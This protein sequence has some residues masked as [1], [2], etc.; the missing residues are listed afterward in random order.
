MQITEAEIKTVKIHSTK[1]NSLKTFL[2]KLS[3]NKDI[4]TSFIYSYTFQDLTCFNQVEDTEIISYLLGH[5][6]DLRESCDRLFRKNSIT[7]YKLKEYVKELKTPPF[8]IQRTG[9]PADRFAAIENA[10]CNELILEENL[11]TRFQIII[12]IEL[13]HQGTGINKVCSITINDIEQIRGK[14]NYADL[15]KSVFNRINPDSH[16]NEEE[17]K[18]VKQYSIRYNR[19]KTLLSKYPPNNEIRTEFALY[20]HFKNLQEYTETNPNA[21]LSVLACQDEELMHSYETIKKNRSNMEWIMAQEDV[22]NQK[23]INSLQHLSFPYTEFIATEKKLCQKLIETAK[24]DMTIH[25]RL[26]YGNGPDQISNAYEYDYEALNEAFEIKQAEKNLREKAN[27]TK[28]KITPTLRYNTLKRDGFRCALCGAVASDG[29]KLEA[30]FIVSPSNGGKNE[31][32][33]LRTLCENCNRGIN[34]EF[35]LEER[36]KMNS[37]L[38]ESILRRDGYRCVLCGATEK[39]GIKLHVDHIM[40]VSKG[41]KTTADNLRTLCDRC[42]FGKHD[43]FD[44]YGPN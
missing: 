4:K 43:K 30:Y 18:I 39:D 20:Y 16:E 40:P 2:S 10:I 9:I 21:I 32:N 6:T 31:L 35:A 5:K 7:P 41:G 44:E 25:V 34:T 38:R 1:Y 11:K 8:F 26:S 15:E 29:A 13:R 24:V 36:A 33:N 3:E 19:L 27:D 23:P 14:E 17:N 28:G 42:N 12:F 37:A 22:Y